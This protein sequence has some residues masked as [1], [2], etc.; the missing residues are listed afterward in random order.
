LIEIKYSDRRLRPSGIAAAIAGG[1][2]GGIWPRGCEF[3]DM[4]FDR[5]IIIVIIARG[6]KRIA[7]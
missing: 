2:S 1:Y 3:N 5:S 7:A 6:F 4:Q